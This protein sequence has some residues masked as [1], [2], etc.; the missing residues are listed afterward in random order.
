MLKAQRIKQGII[1]K[2]HFNSIILGGD[3][4]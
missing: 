1:E 2:K 4:P 3:A